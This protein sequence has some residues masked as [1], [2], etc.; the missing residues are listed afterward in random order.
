MGLKSKEWFYK[1]CLREVKGYT[2]FAHLSWDLL[3]KGIGQKDS[4]RG[5]VTQAIGAVQQFLNEFPEYTQVVQNAS[6]TDPFDLRS[7]ERIHSNWCSW[8]AAH[9]GSYGNPRFGY[10]YD[11]LTS[12]LTPSLGGTRQ[13]GG[14]GDDELKRVFRLVAEFVG[15]A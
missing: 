8:L 10:D 13:G 15:R 4:T 6:K 9:T 11:T 2:A 3:E 1:Q 5:H 14:G 12:Y 7:H